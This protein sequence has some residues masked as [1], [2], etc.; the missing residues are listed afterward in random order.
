MDNNRETD[1]YAH[2]PTQAYDD[3][4]WTSKLKFGCPWMDRDM[5]KL[6]LCLTYEGS[7]KGSGESIYNPGF[8][9]YAP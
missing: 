3:G 7:P 2:G 8:H 9:F 1:I 6:E 5:L 4:P